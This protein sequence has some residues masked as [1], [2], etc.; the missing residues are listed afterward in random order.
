MAAVLSTAAAGQF[1]SRPW[2]EV[3]VGTIV[4]VQGGEEIPADLVL[5]TS[6]EANGVAYVETSNID[7]ETNLK[8]PCYLVKMCQLGVSAQ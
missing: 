2:R 1:E 6:S 3:R 7:G 5:L 4:Q 8:V